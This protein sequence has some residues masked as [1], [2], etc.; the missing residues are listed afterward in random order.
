MEPGGEEGR[1]KHNL[2]CVDAEPLL[3]LLEDVVEQGFIDCRLLARQA[4]V[5]TQ[6]LT[7]EQLVLGVHSAN[8]HLLPLGKV[9]SAHAELCCSLT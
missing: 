8:P 2:E 3:A 9:C 4:R 7:L 6:L 5:Q 1:S